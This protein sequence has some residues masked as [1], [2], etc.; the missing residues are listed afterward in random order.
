[1]PMSNRTYAPLKLTDP[2]PFGKHKGEL[3]GTIIE[4]DDGKYI[5]WVINNTDVQFA[6]EVY[7]YVMECMA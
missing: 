5:F 7:V 1:M 4:E 2:M 3:V 6:K